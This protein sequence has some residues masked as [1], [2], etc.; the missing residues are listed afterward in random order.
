[1]QLICGGKTKQSLPRFKLRDGFSLSCNPKHFS[2]AMESIKLINEI[3]IPYVQS[4]RKELG[5]PKQAALVIMDVFRGQI[6][7]D[8]ISLLRDSNIHY[9]LV[10]NN[11]TQLFQPLDLTDNKHCKSY[12]KRLF[13]EW[14]AQ[15]IENQLALGKKVEEIKIEIR[16]TT[17]KPLH[18][19]WLV[20][21]YSEI[22]SGNG[23]S[24]IINGWKVAGIYD[25]IK[26]G[27]SGYNQWIHSKISHLL[28]PNMMN[29]NRSCRQPSIN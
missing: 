15:Q 26:A 28:S 16:L 22:T 29:Q 24:V 11:M 7:D 19:K 1:M 13:S 20:E 25:A 27:S 18:A 17:L 12:L 21:Y 3:I 8:V 23:S 9:I 6:T 14:Y 10:A 4:Q 2:N 5:K